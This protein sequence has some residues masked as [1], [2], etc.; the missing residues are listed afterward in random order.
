LK[1]GVQI[2]IDDKLQ[3]KTGIIPRVLEV[4]TKNKN[5]YVD[6]RNHLW[7]IFSNE[8]LA[9]TQITFPPDPQPYTSLGTGDSKIESH[10]TLL[11]LAKSG[12][13]IKTPTVI[14]LFYKNPLETFPETNIQ[15]QDK[16]T[17][18]RKNEEEH[19]KLTKSHT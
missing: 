11:E 14:N 18:K 5:F 10:G 7:S 1:S 13:T 16:S 19:Q 8:I 6:L 12:K 2:Y 3:K 4:D 17:C 15:T 9:K